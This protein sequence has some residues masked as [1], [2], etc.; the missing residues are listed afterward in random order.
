M[1]IHIHTYMYI[2]MCIL[3][4]SLFRVMGEPPVQ[5]L[6]PADSRARDRPE[7]KSSALFL[8]AGQMSAR[9]DIIRDKHL[10]HTTCLTHVFFKSGKSCSKGN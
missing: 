1:C 5:M 6:A 7:A 2:M 3:R 8:P 9:I 4:A 10:S